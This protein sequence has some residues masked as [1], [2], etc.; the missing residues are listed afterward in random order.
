[1]SEIVREKALL[2]LEDRDALMAVAR[3]VVEENPKAVADY[4]GGKEKAFTSLQGA[5]MKKTRGKANPR[6]MRELIL[7]LIQPSK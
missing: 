2:Q 3:E 6:L 7:E 1:M 5:A 4:L